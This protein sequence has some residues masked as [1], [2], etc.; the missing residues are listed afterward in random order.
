[1]NRLLGLFDAIAL[2]PDGVTLARLS[3]LLASP[4][5]SLLTLLRPLVAQGYLI[6]KDGRYSLGPEIYGLAS[7]ILATRKFSNLMRRFMEDLVASSGETVILATLDKIAEVIIYQDVIESPQSVRYTVPAGLTRAPYTTAG[8]RLLLAYQD[9]DW[10][11]DYLARTKLERLTE[12]SVTDVDQLRSILDNI[13]KTGISISVGE[14]VEGAAGVAAPI[15]SGDGRIAAALVVG[16]PEN[17]AK[18]ERDKLVRLTA[19]A[20][21]QASRA[22]GYSGSHVRAAHDAP[23]GLLGKPGSVALQR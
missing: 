6:H 16:A 21:A 20:A 23:P 8:G 2:E 10:R 9:A 11:E 17:R 18:L 14:A 12:R 3:V 5:S 19:E 15:F 7:N 4:K 13:R 22:L 1:M